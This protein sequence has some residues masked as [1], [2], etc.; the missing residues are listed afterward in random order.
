MLLQQ[1]EARAVPRMTALKRRNVLRLRILVDREAI[2]HRPHPRNAA[3]A[4][5]ERPHFL[6][7]HRAGERHVAVVGRDL[8]R[9]R[10]RHRAAELGAHAFDQHGIGYFLVLEELARGG[11]HAARTVH[12]VARGHATGFIE[13]LARVHHLVACPRAATPPFSRI[14]EVHREG[15]ERPADEEAV[16]A[17]FHLQVVR[18]SRYGVPRPAR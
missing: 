3:H 5:Q 2:A 8:E 9:A 14:Q 13:P 1:L 10:M 12:R 18:R 15:A 17:G 11:E 6:G 16:H 7:E 4:A